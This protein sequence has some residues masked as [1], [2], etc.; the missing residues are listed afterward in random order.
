[1]SESGPPR[2][3]PSDP[4]EHR[5]ETGNRAEA[6]KQAQDALAQSRDLAEYY[7]N[8]LKLAALE[9]APRTPEEEE[10]QWRSAGAPDKPALGGWRVALKRGCVFALPFLLGPPT[11]L[12]IGEFA[13]P[14]Y[15]HLIRPAASA[16]ITMIVMFLLAPAAFL[17]GILTAKD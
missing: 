7:D 9:S 10:Q 2:P 4:G 17:I 3:A 14:R 13:F 16:D 6:L 12:L 8:L 5:P 1:M 15:L 11:V